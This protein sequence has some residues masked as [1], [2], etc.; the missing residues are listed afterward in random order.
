MIALL[1]EQPPFWPPGQGAGYHAI[2]WGYLAGQLVRLTTGR[3]LGEVFRD[4][5]AAPLDADC[6]IGLPASER[7]RVA[8]MISAS[9]ARIQPDPAA[10]AA[11]TA[12]PLYAVALGNPVIRPFA[13]ASSAAW[14]GAE[15][16]AANGTANARG[17]ARV[18]AAAA[19]GGAWNGTRILEPATLA[20]LV[21]EEVGLEEDL[22]LGRALRRGRGVMLNTDGQYGP[23]AGAFGHAGAG[24]SVG[25]ADP[26]TRVAIGYAKNQMQT[27]LDGDT[28][29]GRLARAV[30]ASL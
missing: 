5:I 23:G 11:L 29:A 2:V 1:E 12:P 21:V 7:A 20:A 17:I 28:R 4:E 8:P 13:D 19:N 9:R 14:Q 25:F 30:Y 18:Y 10:L 15:I 26:H 27:N 24:G 6:W 3:T 16:A 22:V